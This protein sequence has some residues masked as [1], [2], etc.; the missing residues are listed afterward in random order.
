MLILNVIQG[1][2]KGRRFDLPDTEP[3]LI[4][5]SSES[6]PLT[7]TTISRRHAELTPDDGKWLINDLNSANGTYVNGKRISKPMLLRA[8]DQIRTG[9][10]LFVFGRVSNVTMKPVHVLDADRIDTSVEAAVPS[11]D[12]S[13]IMASPDPSEAAQLHL[14]ILYE[15]M[16]LVGSIFDKQLLLER[17]MD[18]VFEH[19]EPDRG[20]VLLRDGRSDGQPEP[21]VVRWRKQ[22]KTRDEEK[23]AVS[24]TIV[25]HVMER[26]E[27]VLSSNAM[28]DRRFSAG[29]SVHAYGIRSAI[30]VPVKFRQRTFGVIYIDS[31]IANYTFTHD[32]LRLMTAIGAQTGLALENA[33]LYQ[34]GLHRARLVAVGETVASLSHSIRNILQ[35]LRGGGE[36][37]ELG[38]RKKDLNLVGSG[39]DILRRNL[40]R[41]Y[42][43]TMNMLAF[44]KQRKPEFEMANLGQL[45]QEI[46]EL[47]QPQCDRRN[48]ALIT[49]LDPDMPPIPMDPGGIHQA[50]MNLMGNALDAVEADRGVITLRT[51]FDAES[52]EASISVSDNGQGMDA[53]SLN[54]V[55]TPFYSTKG[56][57]GTGLGLAVAKKVIDEHGGRV[58]VQS[59]AGEGSTFT[60]R[61][62]T[63]WRHDPAETH[64]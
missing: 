51:E 63:E 60:I 34:E 58:V 24:R 44:S 59:K 25:Q 42:E 36:V 45:L 31:K 33:E 38:L 6:L 13:V 41:I 15:L 40:D 39:W 2:D 49:E 32:Q 16:Q 1:P 55:F 35:A 54:Q 12:D 20:F 8:G 48:I 19:F 43:L 21:I 37:V 29:D 50:L 30:C 56:L 28:T 61:L 5:R 7:D 22:P 23:I 18:L 4:G 17:V 27:G 9:S 53:E 52:Q 11:N 64:A 14:T 62:K 57:R 26:A 3:Q 47:M 46:V 10:T